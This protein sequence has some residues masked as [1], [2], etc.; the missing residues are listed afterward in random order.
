M[1]DESRQLELLAQ[2]VRLQGR[3]LVAGKNQTEAITELS[4][5]GLDRNE[6]A[7]VVGTSP[8]VV[9]VRLAESRRGKPLR[10]VVKRAK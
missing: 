7:R 3:L 4:G 10:K 9:S 2:L 6:I 1:T 8:A 5:V